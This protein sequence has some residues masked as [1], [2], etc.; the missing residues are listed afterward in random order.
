VC[1]GLN[2][3]RIELRLAAARFFRAFP[4]ARVSSREGMSDKDMD[5]RVYVLLIPV[6]GRCLIEAV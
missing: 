4:N 5:P 1:L 2:L 3:A 6:G